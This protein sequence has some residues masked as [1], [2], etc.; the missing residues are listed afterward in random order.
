LNILSGLLNNRRRYYRVTKYRLIEI[1]KRRPILLDEPV[2]NRTL[3]TLLNVF[4]VAKDGYFRVI[5]I[6]ILRALAF[7]KKKIRVL[8]KKRAIEQRLY[9]LLI[10]RYALIVIRASN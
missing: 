4:N 6:V 2:K 1:G 7:F 5:F 8:L 3:F 10:A 9:P